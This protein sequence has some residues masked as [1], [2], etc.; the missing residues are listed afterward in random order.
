M[1]KNEVLKKIF[2]SFNEKVRK[3]EKVLLLEN[4]L[5]GKDNKLK[6]Y[7]TALHRFYY[8]LRVFL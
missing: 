2:E 8:N 1:Q 5:L 7:G 4:C 6:K 3:N